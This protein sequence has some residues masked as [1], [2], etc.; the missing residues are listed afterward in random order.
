MSTKKLLNSSLFLLGLMLS[1]CQAQK[2][3]EPSVALTWE[4]GKN[5]VQPGY[6]ESTFYVKNTGT[7]TLSGDW[8]IYFNQIDPIISEQAAD[9]APLKIEWI[10]SNYHK[11][12]P[13]AHYRPLAPG[14]TL[15]FTYRCQG[16]LIREALAPEGAYIVMRDKK[17]NELKPQNIPIEVVP[18]THSYQWADSGEKFPYSD[19]NYVYKQNAFFG[20]PCESDSTSI[21]P[22]P[23]SITKTPGASS[24]SKS[25]HLKFAPEFENEAA[26]LKEKLISEFGCTVSE[27][28][29]TLVDLEKIN[30]G[31]KHPDEYY[32]INISNNQFNLAGPD[33]HGVFNA[34][35]TLINLLEN[36]NTL[37]ARFGNMRIADYPD[38]G[39]RGLMLDVARNFTKKENILKLI[40]V[41]SSYKLNVL[42]LHLTD[43]EAWRIEIPGLEELTQIGSRRGHTTDESTCLYPM[44]S[45]G[46]DAS[47][48]T[49]LAN[50]YY[51]RNDFI[52]ILKY[53]QKHHIQIIP[54]IDIPGHSRAAIKS[55]NARYKKYITTDKAKAE[56]YL[57]TDFA[58]SSKYLS[59]QNFSDNVMNAAMPSTY[60]FV[61]KIIDEIAK[62]YSAAGAELTVFHIGGDEVPHGVWE[63]S[64]I[65]RNFV[66]EKGMTGIHDLKD[67]FLEQVLPMLSKR[68][69]QPAGWE[70][71]ALTSDENTVN[72]RFKD[73]NV[74]S[75]CWNTMSE[76]G[77]DEVPYKLA[78]SGYPIILSNVT[79]FYLDMSYCNHEQEKGLSWG[80]YV[81]E[82][83]SF[84]MLPY[85][86]FKSIRQD[87]KGDSINIFTVSKAKL[88]LSKSARGQIKG[89]QAQ[90]WAETIRSF[91][92]VEYYLFPKLFGLIERAWNVQPDWSL[93]TDN[94][95][96]EKAKKEYN[97]QIACYEL[98][99][100]A[101][102]GVNFR[103]A[104][105]GIV[106]RNGLLYA[107]S[108]IPE[109]VIRYT[110]DGSEPTENSTA[111]T[112]PISCNTKQV[113][114]KAFYLGKKSL[115][116]VLDN[117]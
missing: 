2:S 38:V 52:D 81:N 45:W 39:Y 76:R 4:M 93:S 7:K 73:S 63:G 32:E 83:N 12:V 114:A 61:E 77:R 99:R 68:H 55:M 78:N 116:T 10:T 103:V 26:L 96:Y 113:K 84:D 97:A 35:Q 105:P 50:G 86:I 67:Y 69:I 88:P 20:E 14:E 25:V 89:L 48:T 57:L 75:Y 21:F 34:C 33:A 29:E 36:A 72:E 16:S 23:K 117:E 27:T 11:M 5:N 1:A 60:R 87:M 13:T 94:Q 59:A 58:D 107:N 43:D 71:I 64:D 90:V 104:L 98:P 79:N 44:F 47:D 85:D 66:K 49:S 102:K 40:D 37:P 8:T 31:A 112:E 80:G 92:Q 109:A 100:L 115:T 24:F 56:E 3:G 95:K 101:K 82:Y 42:H 41:L 46:W 106:I 54:E 22:H 9:D 74:L 28:S 108:T 51:S 17:G 111:W 62:M 18:F 91:D 53:A 110:I 65:C 70:E 30:S 6:Y 19:G 15:K